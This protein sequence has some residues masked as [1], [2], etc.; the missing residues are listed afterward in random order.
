LAELPEIAGIAKDAAVIVHC[1]SGVRSERAAQILS[2]AGY[3]N[4][5]SLTGGVVAWA[6]EHDAHRR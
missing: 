5:R 1:H 3:T 2:A 6:A 4:V